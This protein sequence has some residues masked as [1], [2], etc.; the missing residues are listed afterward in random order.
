[1]TD[2]KVLYIDLWIYIIR[3]FGCLAA[4]VRLYLL[5]ILYVLWVY[6]EKVINEEGQ[7]LTYVYGVSITVIEKYDVKEK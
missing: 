5:Y 4:F 2:M 6:D 1:M 7:Q 3:L